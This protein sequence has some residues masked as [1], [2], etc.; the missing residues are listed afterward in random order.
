MDFY[1]RA[2]YQALPKAE[3]EALL[4][5]L[6]AKQTG[7]F[8]FVRMQRF[9]AFGQMMDTALLHDADGS[10][11]V[12]VPGDTVTLGWHASASKMDQKTRRDLA[13]A[14]GDPTPEELASLLSASCTPLRTVTL[15]PMLVERNVRELGWYDTTA[16]DSRIQED[17]KLRHYLEDYLAQPHPGVYELDETLKL[18][19]QQGK[20]RVQLY[21]PISYQALLAQVRSS[22][23]DLPTEDEWEYLCGGG[24]RTFWRWGD[25]FD[26]GMEI[27]YFATPETHISWNIAWPNQFGLVIA[28]DP[29]R[30][31]VVAGGDIIL[32]AGD[33]GCNICGGGG[34]AW[35]FLPVGT[36]YKG[37]DRRQDE[38][39]YLA[40]IG[41]DNSSYRRVLRL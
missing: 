14:L 31:E 17:E 8:S 39:G 38:L 2:T 41:G 1:T 3:K 25:S 4:R 27:P 10:E 12:F 36:Y 28:C 23:F 30:Y 22:G 20:L 9:S 26:Y 37:Y 21:R 19:Y 24:L 35:G 15:P 13:E 29:Y 7:K 18:Q 34:P 11:F 33:G 5:E 32:K 16:D 6:A 40:D